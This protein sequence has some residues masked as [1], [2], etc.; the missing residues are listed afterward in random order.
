MPPCNPLL[1][2]DQGRMLP[3]SAARR[4][5][6]PLAV[7]C[8]CLGSGSEEVCTVGGGP[9]PAACGGSVAPKDATLDAEGDDGDDIFADD[10]D[11]F[12]DEP[13]PR[14]AE[15][16]FLA[17]LQREHLEAKERQGRL[18]KEV[19]PKVADM[20]D[21]VGSTVHWVSE[22]HKE[23]MA[24]MGRIEEELKQVELEFTEEQRQ[25]I[26]MLRQVAE[27][28]LNKTAPD[29]EDLQARSQIAE[30]DAVAATVRVK[31][32]PEL[33]ER[34]RQQEERIS[35][36][37]LMLLREEAPPSFYAGEAGELP[38]GMESLA[39]SVT[40]LLNGS[41]DPDDPHLLIPGVTM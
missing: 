2:R 36:E 33:A 17:S 14:A 37:Q 19:A 12:A 38:L 15:E 32:T 23:A 25:E 27:G 40:G 4:L 34:V 10:E 6:V 11:I 30:F 41:V 16:D 1:H 7:L 21:S 13:P 5:L 20:Y 26:E 29:V 22:K 35:A 39:N 28:M 31:M 3:G 24:I 9:S 8:L 18:L